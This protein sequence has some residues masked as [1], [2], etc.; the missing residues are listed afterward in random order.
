M[1]VKNVAI[2]VLP[3]GELGAKIL[4]SLRLWRSVGMISD[5]LVVPIEELRLE[6]IQNY[7]VSAKWISSVDDEGLENLFQA[8]GEESFNQRDLIIP[9]F[10]GD[11][12]ADGEMAHLGYELQNQ[13][14]STRSSSMGE[15]KKDQNFFSSL[16]SIP[17]YQIDDPAPIFSTSL[18]YTVFH[19]NIFVSPEMKIVPG[20]A[21]VPLKASQPTF[22]PYIAAQIVTIAGLWSGV[23]YP[24]TRILK[25]KDYTFA[26]N[27][28]R[29]VVIRSSAAAVIASGLA[30]KIISTSLERVLDNSQSPYDGTD[31]S[32][33]TPIAYRSAYPDIVRD[34]IEDYKRE[35]INLAKPKQQDSS[36][37]QA[38]PTLRKST[39]MEYFPQPKPT[40]VDFER[41]LNV[42]YRE[43]LNWIK[44]TIAF[45][46]KYSWA[47]VQNTFASLMGKIL[48]DIKKPVPE[49]NSNLDKAAAE[50]IAE[51]NEMRNNPDSEENRKI[52]E[53]AF[54][55]DPAFFKNLRQI[56]FES[57]DT[58]REKEK[59][60]FVLPSV[61]FVAADP[62]S[63]F[64]VEASLAQSLGIS[65]ELDFD[66]ATDVRSKAHET[67][68]Y[69]EARALEVRT[70]LEGLKA[71]EIIE[72]QKVELEEYEEN[73]SDD[74]ESELV[75]DRE[76]ENPTGDD[77][78]DE[79]ELS[80][81]LPTFTEEESL[82][83]EVQEVIQDTNPVDGDSSIPSLQELLPETPNTQ[84]PFDLPAVPQNLV[85]PNES[86]N[87]NLYEPEVLPGEVGLDNSKET[88]P[89]PP[90]ID[91]DLMKLF[92]LD[93]DDR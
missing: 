52:R 22:Y 45:M 32:E 30:S 90:K 24:L 21:A 47:W 63:K 9:W 71:R 16:V 11:G 88:V 33:M 64:V 31:G 61:D 92:E 1:S 25:K 12:P 80:L 54:R 60:Y 8:L 83:S 38:V 46:P 93:E 67:L 70:A 72:S 4:Q 13:I 23:R 55:P 69:L 77:F 84:A 7:D 26:D 57:L 76:E 5:A 2:I 27:E 10:I 37:D 6:R 68:T 28:D 87:P 51:I 20:G 14:E 41:D 81:V 3:R 89:A 50:K 17:T 19:T 73:S 66:T 85:A 65:S 15:T 42:G 34:P 39:P 56:I 91:S 43:F 36:E 79:T 48:R 82:E 53:L 59:T 29:V 58:G 40:D 35:I 18:D 75:V 44:Q 62:K 74:F 49:Y 78:A 86:V